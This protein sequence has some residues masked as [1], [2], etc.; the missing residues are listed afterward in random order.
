[1]NI[2]EV[3]SKIAKALKVKPI[4]VPQDVVVVPSSAEY[5]DPSFFDLVPLKS[6]EPAV[7]VYFEGGETHVE[8]C[9]DV[10]VCKEVATISGVVPAY[11]SYDGKGGITLVKQPEG[12]NVNNQ[13]ANCTGL[14]DVMDVIGQVMF[15]RLYCIDLGEKPDK[16]GY[17][18]FLYPDQFVIMLPEIP[19]GLY[20]STK[21]KVIVS[22]K[23]IEA[24]EAT[25][26][27]TL[28]GQFVSERERAKK[29]TLGLVYLVLG[30]TLFFGYGLE[31][32][33]ETKKT[34]LS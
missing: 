14:E 15:D 24:V 30:R 4:T 8:V 13:V 18:V 7:D 19:H 10:D 20:T 23:G 1:M 22:N 11:Y 9:W 31:P 33:I 17:S 6:L 12:T 21:R 26:T 16:R 5:V 29:R 27:Y 2:S 25:T 28:L 34:N 3:I 32:L